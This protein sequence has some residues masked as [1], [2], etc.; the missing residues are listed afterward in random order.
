MEAASRPQENPKRPKMVKAK[1]ALYVCVYGD[2]DGDSDGDGDGD[3]GDENDN[4][5]NTKYMNHVQ[6]CKHA[7]GNKPYYGGRGSLGRGSLRHIVRVPKNAK[8]QINMHT[9]RLY[10]ILHIKRHFRVA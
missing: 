3:G 1:T 6:A 9:C 8:N 10:C 5:N 2:G 7:S 4:I